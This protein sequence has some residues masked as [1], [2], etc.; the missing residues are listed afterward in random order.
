MYSNT[1]SGTE[2][3]SFPCGL[4][5]KKMGTLKQTMS[6]NGCTFDED[7]I[8][9]FLTLDTQKSLVATSDSIGTE[10]EKEN[11]LVVVN[12][13]N[14]TKTLKGTNSVLLM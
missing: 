8:V 13:L 12:G 10:T 5:L 7:G 3:T 2:C 14:L 11:G 4:L 6:Q 1:Y 9:K